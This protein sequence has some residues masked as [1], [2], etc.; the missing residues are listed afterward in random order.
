[1][2]EVEMREASPGV[3]EPVRPKPKAGSVLERLTDLALIVC[4]AVNVITI[5]NVLEAWLR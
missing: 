3:W 1:M 4:I 5:S 2:D